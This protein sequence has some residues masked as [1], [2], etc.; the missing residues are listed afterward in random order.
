MVCQG[1]PGVIEEKPVTIFRKPRTFW[2]F[3]CLYMVSAFER[4]VFVVVLFWSTN[5]VCLQVIHV[6][7]RACRMIG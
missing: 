5:P 3:F 1:F 2:S 4:S 7:G 6:M